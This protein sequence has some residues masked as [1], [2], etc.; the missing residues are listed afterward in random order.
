MINLQESLNHNE[1][2]QK[3]ATQR[4]IRH[5]KKDTFGDASHASDF[6][7]LQSQQSMG[8]A[9]NQKVAVN[10]RNLLGESPDVR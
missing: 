6:F 1:K 9:S 2:L 4:A 3:L 8:C 10:K 5:A 7:Q